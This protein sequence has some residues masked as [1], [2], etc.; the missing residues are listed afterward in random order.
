MALSSM[1]A[2]LMA[3]M[4]TPSCRY[5]HGLPRRVMLASI[6]SSDTRKKACSSSVIQPSAAALKYSSSE[7]GRP[8]SMDTESGTDM[9][10]LHFPPT[11][12]IS[13]LYGHPDSPGRVRDRAPAH[14]CRKK[15]K[16]K[17]REVC[18]RVLPFGTS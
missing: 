1:M 12:F 11:V 3:T 4:P 5:Q 13:R 18:S 10:R 9:P 8:S 6:M 7:R 14:H 16:E 17:K 2:S 15:K